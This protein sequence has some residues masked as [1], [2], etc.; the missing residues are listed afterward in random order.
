MEAGRPRQGTIQQNGWELYRDRT[1][2]L[3][4]GPDSNQTIRAA[5]RTSGGRAWSWGQS[6]LFPTS[7]S[8]SMTPR[9]R[10]PDLRVILGKFRPP[11]A[12]ESVG[13]RDRRVNEYEFSV[14]LLHDRPLAGSGIPVAASAYSARRARTTGRGGAEHA[15]RT[16]EDYVSTPSPSTNNADPDKT[17]AHIARRGTYPNL[18]RS[19]IDSDED[20]PPPGQSIP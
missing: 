5:E 9:P 19:G 13:P 11:P 20:L 16:G 8:P 10:F 14:E 3:D 6:S 1:N 7:A 17:V 15:G 4:R 2:L 18:F 12:I